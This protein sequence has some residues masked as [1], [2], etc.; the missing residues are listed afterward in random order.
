MAYSAIPIFPSSGGGGDGRRIL[1][2]WTVPSGH[3]FDAGHVV[4]YTAGTTGFQLGLADDL[5]TTQTV[6]IVEATTTESITV[7]Y[8]GEIDFAG[9]SLLIDDGTTSLTAGLVYYLSPTNEGY[10]TSVRPLDGASFVQGVLVATDTHEGI[11]INS[12]PQAP[13]TAS[14]YTPVGAIIPFAGPYS[15]IPETW[16]IC[17]GAAVRKS[18]ATPLDDET[19]A[20]L[21]GV[22]GD[23]YKVTGLV[24]DLTG[25]VSNI[26]RDV[27]ISFS[28]E[29]H[30]DYSGT[31]AHG[32]LDAYGTDTH[33]Q[34]KIGWGGTNDFAVAALTAASTSTVRFHFL[35]PYTGTSVVN[36]S[37]A[38]VNA[39]ITI[40]SLAD[41]EVAGYTSQRFFI[42]DLRART[43]FGAGYS[44]GLTGTNRG[45][46][47]GEDLYLLTTDDIPDHINKVYTYPTNPAPDAGGGGTNV[48][49]LIAERDNCNIVQAI[50]HD[51]SFTAD[52]DPINLLPPHVVTN[53]I[54]RH[55]PFEGPGVEVGPRGPQGPAGPQGPSGGT[56]AT[57]ADGPPG[58]AGP[59]GPTGQD[60]ATGHTGDEGP[61]GPAGPAGE[62]NC[63]QGGA[64]G[65]L[66]ESIHLAATSQ[67][68]NGI[69]GNA[70]GTI[71]DEQISTDPLYPTDFAYAISSLTMTGT[72]IESPST[73]YFRDPANN[74][75]EQTYTYAPTRQ[76]SPNPYQGGIRPS[77]VNGA[78]ISPPTQ[79]G[80][81]G[82]PGQCGG[83]PVNPF[84]IVLQ[85]GVYTLDKSIYTN[86]PRDLYIGGQTGSVINQTISSVTVL[87]VVDAG[88]TS[89]TAFSLS[90]NIGTAQSM[91]AATGTAIVVPP[92]SSIV[93]GSIPSATGMYGLTATIEGATSGTAGFFNSLAGGYVVKGISGQTFTVDVLTEG[94]VTSNF[95]NFFNQTYQRYINSI[96]VYRVTVHTTS[97][98]GIFFSE[99]GT[100]TYFGD[101][102]VGVNGSELGGIAFVNDATGVAL[103][104]SSLSGFAPSGYYSNAK[105]LETDG[106]LIK[107]NGCVFINYPVA[108]H[109]FNG[110]S[111]TLSHSYVSNSYYGVAVDSGANAKIEGSVISRSAIPVIAEGA[112]NV[113][114]THD[115]SHV[116]KSH[117]IANKGGICTINTPLEVGST[118]IFGPGVYAENS[119]VKVKP[120]TEIYSQT[121]GTKGSTEIADAVRNNKFVILA[122]NSSVSTP[123]M[124]GANGI[125][126]TDPVTKTTKKKFNGEGTFQG[127][128]SKIILSTDRL[129]LVTPVVDTVNVTETIKGNA[130]Q[131]PLS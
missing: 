78:I 28:Q 53:W 55:R 17:D 59:T 54:I 29:G 84:R 65:I 39:P 104:D 6:G 97:Q 49:A 122:I 60:G 99:K 41:G 25:P 69:V 100:R 89:M 36:F 13:T 16:R 26:Y 56:G 120:F 94:G 2:T 18:G 1:N 81:G 45:E 61:A 7:V 9:S 62:C 51:S 85:N 19:Y 107:A 93:Y 74:P 101:S 121:D 46:I 114:I 14:L 90:F 30:E 105:G 123:D 67:Y 75:N 109:A 130:S 73:F 66:V 68:K 115:L 116:G 87:P 34:Y 31:T 32:L 131:I 102:T 43:V 3:P 98:D 12:L 71:L 125:S 76:Y 47:K 80:G 8:Q 10:L 27:I 52:N 63:L 110:G 128:N 117:M 91:I 126:G 77:V 119:S 22:I 92:P 96:D 15:E 86:L 50:V 23:K 72:N 129:P 83:G 20:S 4:L 112:A 70:S 64:G 11:V 21:Y 35:A 79:T 113:K 124:Y 5:D 106:G 82:G 88:A 103:N 48:V 37:G 44:V 108:A 40:Q 118:R 58:V 38:S 111:V 42:P 57:G 127:I 24:S 33:K 95:G